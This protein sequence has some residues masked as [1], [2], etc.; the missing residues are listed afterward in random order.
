[1]AWHR[2][3]SSSPDYDARIDEAFASVRRADFLPEAQRRYEAEDRPL[4]IGYSATNSQPRTVHNMLCLL[5]VQRGDRVLDVGSGSGWTSALLG[6]LVGHTGRVFA[7]EV[8]PELVA[9]SRLALES[10][11]RPWVSVHQAESNVL[12]LPAQAP[13]D[14][15]LVSAEART[16]PPPLVD[17][18]TPGGR[19]VIPVHGRMAV[20]DRDN[21]G[22]VSVRKVGHYAFVPLVW[23]G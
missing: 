11:P 18:I 14:R 21:R 13:Y 3:G 22:D 16:L 15:I 19:M 2:R 10:D 17:Q 8:V 4:P 7:V 23:S 9:S 12:G 20:V 1:M 5:D 6:H